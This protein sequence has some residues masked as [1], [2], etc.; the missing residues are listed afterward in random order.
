MQGGKMDNEELRTREQRGYMVV[1]LEPEPVEIAFSISPVGKVREAWR[2]TTAEKIEAV[3]V[4]A[5]M[6]L[7][8]KRVA[9][10]AFKRRHPEY[11]K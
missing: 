11:S 5:K 1:S 2:A 7:R 3:N 6:V 9:V 8:A 4:P 10:S